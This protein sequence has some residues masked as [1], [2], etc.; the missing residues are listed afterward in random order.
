MTGGDRRSEVSP[1]LSRM[2]GYDPNLQTAPVE[3]AQCWE[4]AS[5][6]T[7]REF[8]GFHT[9]NKKL[10]VRFNLIEKDKVM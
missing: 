10:G 7:E 3:R 4:E 1:M 2:L 6:R 9:G 5:C 8:T